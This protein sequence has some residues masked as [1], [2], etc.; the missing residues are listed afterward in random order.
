MNFTQRAML[1]ISRK[2]GKTVSL[3]L[4]V[5][6]V[7]VFLISCFCVLK[8]SARLSK[9]IR[10]SL[11]AAFYIRANTE[12]SMNEKGETE[13]KENNV[14]ISQKEINEIMQTGEIKYYNPINYGFA[15]SD[16]IQFVQGDKHGSIFILLHTDCQ[17]D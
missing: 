13:V 1:Y 12:V 8:A 6:V 17:L 5:F 11:G 7:A 14:Y 2:K 10:T 16:T 3:F 9:D 15:Q 4:V